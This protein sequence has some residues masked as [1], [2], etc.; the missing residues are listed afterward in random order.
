ML[1][2]AYVLQQIS[3]FGGGA[4]LSFLYFRWLR[5]QPKAAIAEPNSLPDRA[6]YLL[7]GVLVTIAVGFAVPSALRTASLF[8]GYLAFRVMVFRTGVY[9]VAVFIPLLILSSIALYSVYWREA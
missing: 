2:V 3:T 5:R 7:L 8:D 1:P 9:S 4:F 6:R